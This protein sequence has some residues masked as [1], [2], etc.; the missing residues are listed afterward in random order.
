MSPRKITS[1]P[2]LF[3]TVNHYDENGNYLGYSAES[4][5]SGVNHYDASGNLAGYSLDSAFGGENHYDALGKGRWLQ[6]GQRA[7]RQ[8]SLS[9]GRHARRVFRSGSF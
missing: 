3:G 4:A 8:Q 7:W 1:V 5:L 6:P 9:H 2:G